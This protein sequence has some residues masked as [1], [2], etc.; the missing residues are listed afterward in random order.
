MATTKTELPERAFATKAALVSWLDGNHAKSPG[1][2]ILFGK[3]DSGHRSVTYA[4]ALDAALAYGWI[5][6]LKKTSEREGYYKL[7][8]SPRK[9]NSVWSA[10]NKDK[11]MALIAGGEM[12]AAGLASIETAKRNG[13][14]QNAYQSGSTATVPAELTAALR[15]APKAAKFFATLDRTNR[16]AVIWRVQTAATTATREKRIATLVA[17]LSRGEK[18]HG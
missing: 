5:D 7:R 11:A 8:F 3:K 18:I 16:Y 9:P 15:K 1:L 2:W 17:M 12:R 4:E 6:G 13:R 10:I 14:W